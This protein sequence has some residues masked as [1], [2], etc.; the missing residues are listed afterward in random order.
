MDRL[1]TI[2]SSRFGLDI[3]LRPD[4]DMELLLKNLEEK[5]RHASRFFKNAKMAIS[6]SGRQLDRAEEDE[7]LKIISRNTQIEIV[8]VIEQDADGETTYRSAVEQLSSG[9]PRQDGLFCR[10]TLGRSQVLESESDLVIL[11]DVEPGAKVIAR[12]S[13]VIMG[14]LY[15]SAWAGSGGDRNAFI[16]AL[17]FQPKELRIGDIE[18]KRHII[19]QE[20]LS[21]QGPKIAVADGNRIYLDPLVD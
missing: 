8:C 7:I 14:S 20:S 19:Y 2:R 17:F 6:F 5:F 10:G 15:G 18:A 3:E 21:S 12:G 16:S 9:T 4:V 1:V 13:I 11:G